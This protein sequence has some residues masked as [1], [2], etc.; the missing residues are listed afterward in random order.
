MD[1][2]IIIIII[3]IT[4]TIIKNPS[5]HVFLT[6]ILKFVIKFPLTN[7]GMKQLVDDWNYKNLKWS[8]VLILGTL[9]NAFSSITVNERE[10]L[11]LKSY[12][13]RPVQSLI[14]RQYYIDDEWRVC[15]IHWSRLN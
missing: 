7:C 6:I 2:I 5:D 1:T 4:I 15:W 8:A 3:I 9:K 13:Y 11:N 12:S 10:A 14:H